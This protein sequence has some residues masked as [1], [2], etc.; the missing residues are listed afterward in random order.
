MFQVERERKR[1]PK[2]I[3]NPADTAK[4]SPGD[5]KVFENRPKF[6]S[7]SLGH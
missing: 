2:D 5:F 7:D 1:I 4:T 6:Q 3:K